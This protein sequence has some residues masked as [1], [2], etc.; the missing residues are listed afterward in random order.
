MALSREGGGEKVW[1]HSKKTGLLRGNHSP[2]SRSS[3]S[4]IPGTCP[5]SS[6][7]CRQLLLRLPTAQARSA[8][9]EGG[10]SWADAPR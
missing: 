7:G 1:R 2:A 6:P 5:P 4:E 8:H 3:S 10:K 9:A